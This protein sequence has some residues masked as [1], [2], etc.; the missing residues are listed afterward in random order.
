MTI[1]LNTPQVCSVGKIILQPADESEPSPSRIANMK[2][3]G[4]AS[5]GTQYPIAQHTARQDS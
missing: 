3:V 5:N 2:Q 1:C 4:A